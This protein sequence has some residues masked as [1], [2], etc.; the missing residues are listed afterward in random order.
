MSNVSAEVSEGSSVVLSPQIPVVH[1]IYLVLL[2]CTGV[3]H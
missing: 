3:L 1:Y 2:H